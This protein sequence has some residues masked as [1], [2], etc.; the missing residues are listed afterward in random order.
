M[1]VPPEFLKSLTKRLGVSEGELQVLLD[2]LEGEDLSA[3]AQRLGVQ[4]NALQ[5][6]LGEVYKKFQIEGA[7]PGKFAKLQKIILEEYQKQ[8]NDLQKEAEKQTTDHLD[9]GDAPVVGTFCGRTMQLT[10][11]END[12]IKERCPLVG[13][14]GMAGIG[15]SAIAVRLIESV[16]DNYDY[17]IWRNLSLR[18]VPHLDNLLRDLMAC[19]RHSQEIE[20][21]DNHPP[22]IAD[23]IEEFRASR[24]LVILDNFESVFQANNLASYYQ[25]GYENYGDLLKQVAQTRHQSSI[26]LLSRET[27]LELIT[28]AGDQL[29]TRFM[30]LNGLTVETVKEI[31][32]KKG[33][34]IADKNLLSRLTQDY[35]GHPIAINELVTTAQT[36]FD[37]NFDE[38]LDS[39]PLF[40]GEIL[41]RYFSE[42]FQR[43]SPL[44][45]QVMT[46]LAASNSGLTLK[47]IQHNLS[48]IN[49]LSYV[50]T[51]LSSL[52]RRCL[53]QKQT[54]QK[55]TRFTLIPTLKKYVSSQG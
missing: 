55:I 39:N 34:N 14:L 7:G 33:I 4:R 32:A 13:L 11:L 37:G 21:N 53:L 23:L 36:L 22:L 3:I 50:M 45:K 35:S 25:G 15:K 16:A 9:W 20:T 17:V 52:N 51:A 12:L 30:T 46:H 19:F 40:I 1:V 47:E 44:E 38:L 42:Q 28:L 31:L 6:R 5:K 29:P 49:D 48:D 10:T 27:P 8:I 26:L 54:N 41:S 43:L 2:T 18:G 24:C